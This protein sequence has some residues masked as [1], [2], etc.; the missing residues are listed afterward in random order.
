MQEEIDEYSKVWKDAAKV[1]RYSKI[2]PDKDWEKVKSKL[3]FKPKSKR[4]P[5][6][7]YLLR[8]AAIIVLAF[9]LAYF[10][11]QLVNHAVS[12]E[13]DYFVITSD[14][15][16]LR[17]EMPDGSNIVLNKDAEL[18]YNTSYGNKNRD[19]I[20]DGEAFFEVERNENLP[21]RVFA[22]NSTIEVLGTSF[23]VKNTFNQV[24]LSV[25]SGSVAFFETDNKENRLDLVKNE[26]VQYESEKHL[27]KEKECLNPNLLAWRTKKLIFKNVPL[28]EVL[29][30]IAGYY[31]LELEL[32]NTKDVSESITATFDNQSIEEVL[33][34]LQ[35]GAH[36]SFSTT[37]SKNQLTVTF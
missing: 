14:N 8:I 13:E 20:L 3:D 37:L 35:L 31:D 16:I 4:I 32:K 25:V 12:P 21:F 15:E 1:S 5:F 19:I 2:D 11:T 24:Q 29:S 7:K 36:Q 27:F 9:G 6:S 18:V 26:M 33:E 34:Y 17:H 10:L 23:N 22:G 28:T 30:A